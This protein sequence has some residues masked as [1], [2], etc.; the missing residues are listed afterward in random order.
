[1]TKGVIAGFPDG[2]FKPENNITRQ[3]LAVLGVRVLGKE[4]EASKITQSFIF[5][6]D[7]SKVASWA[8]GAMTIA[9]RPKV[10]ILKW[11]NPLGQGDIC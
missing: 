11:D 4:A 7:E 6:N 3:E 5:A 10:Q 9:V 8:M 2:T 1:V